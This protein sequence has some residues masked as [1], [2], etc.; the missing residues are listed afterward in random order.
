MD[1]NPIAL[2]DP[3]GAST[4]NPPVI[5]NSNLIDEVTCIGKAPG[6]SSSG[7]EPSTVDFGTLV[8]VL[9]TAPIPTNIAFNPAN[10]ALDLSKFSQPVI[11]TMPENQDRNFYDGNKVAEFN[12]KNYE[13]FLRGD[14]AKQSRPV[15]RKPIEG[16]TR[17][18][19]SGWLD[20]V[21]YSVYPSLWKDMVTDPKSGFGSVTDVI[22]PYALANG[23]IR[24]D[25]PKVGDIVFWDAHVEFILSVN[26]NTFV[27]IG[28]SVSKPNDKNVPSDQYYWSGV[29]KN[30]RPFAKWKVKEFTLPNKADYSRN[31]KF[32]GIW[33]PVLP[34]E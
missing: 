20:Y 10:F 29:D 7:F 9:N 2:I 28:S 12:K 3:W 31:T 14:G 23:G 8:P 16:K 24:K 6:S 17:F 13:K 26:G 19:C 25:N 18:D 4:D 11:A 1:A 32:I 30:G 33:T 34:N 22:L 21:L 27:A 5:E 15:Q